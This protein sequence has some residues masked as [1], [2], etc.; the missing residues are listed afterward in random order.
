MDD[1]LSEFF[2]IL[3]L[4]I[5]NGVLAMTEAA[6]IAAKKSR[7]RRQAEEGD[8]SAAIALQLA[9]NPGQFLSTVQIGITLIGILAGAYGG[10]SIA[11]NLAE[12][13][14][15]L[16]GG[17]TWAQPAA[18][19]LV[20]AA[21]TYL[22]LVIGELVPKRLAIA[23]P[24]ATARFL[25]PPTQV[26]S[27][28]TAPAIKLLSFSTEAILKLLRVKPSSEAAVSDEELK[29]MIEE[30]METGAFREDE[31]EMVEGILDLD[32]QRVGDLMTPRGRMV[33]LNIRDSNEALH[34]TVVSSGHSY[35][36]VY[37]DTRDH[38]LGMVS[39][40][41]LWANHTCGGPKQMRSLLVAPL[42]VPETMNAHKLI[43][44][45]RRTGKHI[46]LVTDEYGGISGLVTLIDVMEAIV[47]DLN[48]DEGPSKPKILQREDGSWLVDAGVYIEEIKEILGLEELP[49]EEDADYSSLGGFIV[50]HLGR[51]PI[52]GECFEW[53]G[54]RF[55]VVDMD[56]H[57]VDKILVQRVAPEHDAAPTDARPD[58]A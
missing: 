19:F 45:F 37:E 58:A 8:R 25:A 53:G 2:I 12:S 15:H 50:T 26:L 57:R 18:F 22:S 20:V 51:I 39:V 10:A 42:F 38:V 6:L 3:A 14:Q 11:G 24:E 17:K 56:R 43:E 44:E 33:W 31:R 41:S 28:V 23:H 21:L 34:H 7:L 1:I 40:K 49:Q 32:R 48:D 5:L 46:A 27:K 36:P 55:E 47:G 35:F 9:E 16:P 52:E 54:F 13:L 29:L 30:G 4:V